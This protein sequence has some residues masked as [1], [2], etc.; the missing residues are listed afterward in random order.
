LAIQPQI[1]GK[2]YSLFCDQKIADLQSID[3]PI[4]QDETTECFPLDL[5]LL[6]LDFHL[7]EQLLLKLKIQILQ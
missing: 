7:E 5:A 1:K 3:L 4:T 6:N 2:P